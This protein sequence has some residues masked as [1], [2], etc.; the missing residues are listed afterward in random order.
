MKRELSLTTQLARSMILVRV[1]GLELQETD[2]LSRRDSA[3]SNAA[4]EVAAPHGKR[5]LAVILG[6]SRTSKSDYGN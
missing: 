2:A 1:T 6:L 4:V 5:R 3:L